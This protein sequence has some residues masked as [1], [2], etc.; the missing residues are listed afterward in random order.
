M[1]HHLDTPILPQVPADR[2]CLGCG[3]AA[4][5]G[6]VHAGAHDASDTRAP[7][8]GLVRGGADSVGD[9]MEK[10]NAKGCWEKA[11]GE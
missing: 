8:P 3:K 5:G 7:A 4:G 11:M 10:C 6:P 9:R 2:A 1:G